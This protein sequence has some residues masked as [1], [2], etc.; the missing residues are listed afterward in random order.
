MF[1]VIMGLYFLIQSY[2]LWRYYQLVPVKWGLRWVALIIALILTVSLPLSLYFARTMPLPLMRFFYTIGSA[3]LIGLIYFFLPVFLMDLFRLINWPFQW[4]SSAKL[5]HFRTKNGLLLSILLMG[6]ACFFGW[7]NYT[8]QQKVREH[9]VVTLSPLTVTQTENHPL[10][11]NPLQCQNGAEP[12]RIVLMS[13]LHLG[14]IIGR[15]QLERWIDLINRE[16]PDYIFISGDLI[17][18]DVR[19]LYHQGIE[20]ALS[21]LAPKKEIYAVLG[22]HEY[23]AGVQE[24]IDFFAQTDIQLLR[25]EVVLLPEGFYLVGRDDKM[26]K[27]RQSFDA[28]TADLDPQYP[29]FVL[30]HQPTLNQRAEGDLLQFSG[31]THDG[32]VWPYNYVAKWI[33]G[34]APGLL[35]E[36]SHNYLIS[37]GIGLWGGQFRVGTHS[38]YMV[39]DVCQSLD[40]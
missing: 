11:D 21:R 31:H 19:P 28:L 24:S 23:L 27:L 12:L 17:D 1:I 4:V 13:D 6:Y 20:Q 39:L 18:N 29:L 3:W 26:N 14:H 7:A 32:Q 10:G 34:V 8:Y 30:D 22:N 2:V 25:D 40:H 15:D 33:N 37:S 5:N 38:D 9:Y 36:G 35:Q 16:N